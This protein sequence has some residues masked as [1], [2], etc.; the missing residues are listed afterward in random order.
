M[1]ALTDNATESVP[2][3]NLPGPSEYLESVAETIAADADAIDRDRALTPAVESAL[4][5]HGYFR[6]YLPRSLGGLEM[7][8]PSQNRIIKRLAMADASTAWCVNQGS[9]FATNAA[10]MDRGAAESIWSDP[11]AAIANG[12][13][14]T[15]RAERTDGGYHVNGHWSFSSGCMHA[16]WLAGLCQ[17]HTDGELERR[18]N[19][20]PVLRHMLM[21]KANARIID[22]WQVKGLRGTGS[23]HFEVADE[24]VE[25]RYSVWNYGDPCRES[26][27]LYL[28][29]MVL[30]FAC[31]FASVALGVARACL[32][33]L[34]TLANTKTPRGE[35]STLAQNPVVHSRLGQAEVTWRS[36]DAYL[37]TTVSEVWDAVHASGELT[38]EQRVALRGAT[39]HVIRTAATVVTEAYNVYGSDAI[40]ESADMQRR[41]QDMHVITQHVQGRIAHYEAVGRHAVGVRPDMMWL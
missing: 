20:Q 28:M 23:H 33:D 24:F 1:T 21:P 39:T 19:G 35:P 3:A 17:I 29:P 30:L 26:G 32:D 38:L 16:T 41:F 25:A 18:G 9:V 14:P 27:P 7:D 37:S 4:K 22:E 5:S 2:A 34:I 36:L 8:P 10:Y 11:G 13:S 6:L 12:P 31:G 15:A 40:Y